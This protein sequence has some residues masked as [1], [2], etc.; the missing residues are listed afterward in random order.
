MNTTI[1]RIAT[2]RS[3]LALWQAEFIKAKLQSLWPKLHIELVPM[4]TSGDRFLDDSLQKLGGKG[5][6]VKELEEALLENRADIAVHS[7]KDVPHLFPENLILPVICKRE[8][9]YDAFIS[10]SFMSLQALPHGA[11]IGTSSLRRAAQLLA[12]RPDLAIYP[13][14][15]NVGTRLQRLDEGKYDAIILAAAGL[16]RLNLNERIR[17]PLDKNI[18]LPACGQGALGIECRANDE[19]TRQ[20]IE[21]LHHTQDALCVQ[22][23]RAVNAH[24]GGS[25]HTPVAIFCEYTDSQQLHLEAK[26]LSENGETTLFDVQE[27]LATSW[28]ELAHQCAENLKRK[29]ATQ[30]LKHTP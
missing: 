7:I 14:R 9:P 13:L 28:Q 19:K 8:T 3:P 2:R 15:G 24:L 27:G 26:V 10:P 21:P 23:E 1:F 6:F 22:T 4:T 17:H 12:Y 5:L 25:C 20:L 11:K 30:L 16:T 29:G 18:M